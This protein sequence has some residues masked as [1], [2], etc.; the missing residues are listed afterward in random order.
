M[1]TIIGAI[2]FCAGAYFFLRKENGLLGLLIV[3]SVFEA[4]SALNI[5]ERGIQPHY[6][7]AAFIIARAFFNAMFGLV[8]TSSPMPQGRWLLIFGATAI[9]TTIAFPIVF[10]GTPIYDPKIGI[11]DGLFIRPP[12]KF[13]LNNVAQA[14]FIVWHIATAYAVLW[15]RF[16]APTTRRFYIFAFYLALFFIFAQSFCS[17]VGLPYPDSLLRNNPGYG[18]TD[19]DLVRNGVRCPGTFTEPSIAGAFIAM[20]CIGFAAEYL[21][22]SGSAFRVIL[23]LVAIGLITSSG[24]LLSLALCFLALGISYSPFRFPWYIRVRRA[25]R[26]A[27]IAFLL[28]APTILAVAISSGYRA[29]LIGFTVDKGETGSFV[30]RTASDLYGLQLLLQTYGLGLGLGSNRASSMVTTLLSCTGLLGTLAFGIFYLKLFANLAEEY[31]WLKWAAFAFLLNMC[32]DISD[33]T[34]PLLWLPILLAIQI[35]QGEKL[36]GEKLSH[37]FLSRQRPSEHP[38]TA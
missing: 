23:S 37:R 18:I 14:V 9:V 16:S 36:A 30:N 13:G 11:D 29:T 7:I 3:A 33:V 31:A 1:P 15:I 10:A 25:R 34:F 19:M 17:L 28:F 6:I 38:S 32:I 2:F 22:G 12:L 27:W 8:P 26:I 35:S 5:A 24:A 21:S 4:A 20:Y